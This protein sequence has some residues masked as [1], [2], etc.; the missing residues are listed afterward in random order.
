MLL[1]KKQGGIQKG[2]TASSE[3]SIKLDTQL[4]TI[5]KIV[6]RD[7]DGYSEG[8]RKNNRLLEGIQ[9]G[10][11]PDGGLWF[12]GKL[13]IRVAFEGKH[14]GDHGNA[15]ERHAK[16][17]LIAKKFGSDSFR[18][19]T[20]MTG[21]GARPGGVLDLYAQTMLYCENELGC[22]EINVTHPK[23]FSFYLSEHGFTDEQIETI[24]RAALA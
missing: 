19:I 12:D 3:K 7:I 17:Y 14:Q 15:H 11:M 13:R 21:E 2:T 18:Y 16:N 6:A 9:A 23:G 8:H 5:A 24:M 4:K 10:C 22:N 20:F 1:P